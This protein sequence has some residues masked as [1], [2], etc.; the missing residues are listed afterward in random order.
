MIYFPLNFT[1]CLNQGNTRS[2]SIM[3]LWMVELLPLSFLFCF[4]GFNVGL[5]IGVMCF[6]SL[7]LFTCV[8]KLDRNEDWL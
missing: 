3:E 7:F 5:I 4:S 6:L 2:I 1:L 8:T